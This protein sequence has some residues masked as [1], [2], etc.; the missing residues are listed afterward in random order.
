MRANQ[1]E[2]DLLLFDEP[3]GNTVVYALL[4]MIGIYYL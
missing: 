1:Q 3:V 2:V 4:R